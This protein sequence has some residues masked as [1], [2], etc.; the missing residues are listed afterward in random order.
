MISAVILAKNEEKQ[1]EDAIATVS[2]CD[3]IIVIDNESSDSTTEKAKKAGARIVHSKG[4]NFS[5]HRNLALKKA[6]H[7]WLLYIDCDERISPQLRKDI[8]ESVN[9]HIYDVFAI[10]RVDYFWGKKI[11]R[12]ELSTAA[13]QGIIRLVKKGSGKWIGDVHETFD[14][15]R[16]V[17]GMSYPLEHYAHQS[18]ADFLHDINVYSTVRAQELHKKK[19]RTNTLDILITP[20]G[21]FVYTYFIRLGMLD[22][23]AGFVYSFMMSFHSFLVRGKLYLL[24]AG[25]KGTLPEE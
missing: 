3:E 17:G 8:I 7:D 9:S 1:I 21:K 4:Q 2:F 14:S 16:A 11:R 20:F 6:K 19:K 10:P 15:S 25:V 13:S 18:V 5:E 23:A 22:G 12:G 24:H